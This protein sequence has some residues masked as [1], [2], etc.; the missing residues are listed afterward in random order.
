[1]TE[2]APTYREAGS[3]QSRYAVLSS[4]GQWRP[5]RRPTRAPVCSCH[6]PA[7]DLA[8]RWT[9]AAARRA[10]SRRWVCDTVALQQCRAVRDDEPAPTSSKPMWLRYRRRA[11]SS[12]RRASPGAGR[13]AEGGRSRCAGANRPTGAQLLGQRVENVSRWRLPFGRARITTLLLVLVAAA[14][15]PGRH[16]G[17]AL[18]ETG[19]ERVGPSPTPAGASRSLR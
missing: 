14:L 9:H 7:P 2:S 16:A 15:T 12:A 13:P 4:S 8:G 11:V 1:V 18:K 10:C 6:P 19:A 3:C 17:E 5:A